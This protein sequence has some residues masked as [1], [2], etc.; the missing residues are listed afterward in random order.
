MRDLDGLLREYK[1][2]EPAIEA[3]RNA[4]GLARERRNEAEEAEAS[5]ALAELYCD[6]GDLVAAEDLAQRALHIGGPRSHARAL[7]CLARVERRRHRFDLAL[8]H[9]GGALTYA[10][11][12]DDRAEQVRILGE[13]A[14]ILVL[15]GDADQ[16]DRV[17]REAIGNLKTMDRA[18]ASVEAKIG[19]YRGSALLAAGR[20][21]D[22]LD[23]LAQAK[24]DAENLGQPW[25]GAWIDETRSQAA[26]RKQDLPQSE[27]YA[28]A[29]LDAFTAL[30]NRFGTAHCHYRLGQIHLA[31][32]RADEAVAAMQQAL[33]SFRNCGDRW[34]EGEVA[35]QLARAYR[36]K[37]ESWHAVRLQYA[38]VQ[39]YRRLSDRRATWGAV[40]ELLRTLLAVPATRGAGPR[41]T[42]TSP[43]GTPLT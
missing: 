15:R 18:R 41:D 19:W 3:V 35:L 39:S 28:R 43:L 5:A 13:K 32:G 9:A 11:R 16:A 38:A 12:C 4:I 29:A 17:G 7:W 23:A 24:K 20:L 36:L 33:E 27:A 1:A 6:L 14:L 21:G 26:L 10:R 30:R 42:S 37:A 34:I 2:F 25:Y 22:A 40:K 31:G 8:D